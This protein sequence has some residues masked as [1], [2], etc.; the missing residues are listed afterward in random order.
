MSKDN[1]FKAKNKDLNFEKEKK[2]DTVLGR[3]N[4]DVEQK[5]NF[6]VSKKNRMYQSRQVDN[7]SDNATATDNSDLSNTP[8]NAVKDNTDFT[9]PEQTKTAESVKSTPKKQADKFRSDNSVENPIEIPKETAVHTSTTEFQADISVPVS[10]GERYNI[11]DAVSDNKQ[12][13]DVVNKNT[14]FKLGRQD[15]TAKGT[16]EQ[17]GIKPKNKNRLYQKEHGKSEKETVQNLSSEQSSEPATE[18]S[19]KSETTE[20]AESIDD[21]FQFNRTAKYERRAE[22]LYQKSEKAKKKAPHKTKI[23][24]RRVYDEK[25]QKAKNRLQFEDEPKPSADNRYTFVKNSATF[26]SN[27][28]L[29]KAHNKIREVENENTSVEAAHKTEEQTERLAA[30]SMRLQKNLR[31]RRKNAPLKKAERLRQKAENA[32]IKALYEKTLKEHPEL[33]KS[34]VKKFLQKQRIKKQYQKAKRAEQ[35]AKQA[36]KAA[37]NTRA[38]T[39]R[40]A[41]FVWRH[42]A[43]IGIILAIFLMFMWL[44]SV[45]SSCSIMGT[46]GANSLMVSSY[47]A[48]DEDIYAAEEYYAGLEQNLQSRINNIESEYSGYDEY[49]YN[50][51]G[52]GHNPYELISY[53]TAVYQD[54]KFNDIKS[55]L[56]TLFNT[57]YHLTITETSEQRTDEDGN[58]YTYKILNITLTNSG[59]TTTLNSEQQ[60][61]YN[62]Y[63][64]SKGNRDYLFA[65]DIYS[66]IT[67]SPYNDYEIPSAALSDAT[68]KKLI[69]EAEKYL[70]YPYVWG[71]SSPST[72][73]DCSGFVC[74]VF[75]NSGVYP[76][77]RTTAQGIF[78]QCTAVRPNEAK[79]GDIIF[80]TGTYNSGCPVSHVGIYVGN[81]MMIHCGNPIQYASVN[82]SYWSSHF[83][84]YGRLN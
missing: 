45:L 63:L 69:T 34:Q 55:G 62:I 81:G 49:N 50:V 7:V 64:A 80:F 14:D 73:F 5:D 16:Q 3:Q 27:K 31:A 60:E 6:S 72:S 35:T 78:N 40:I 42:K 9:V 25:K 4:R 70:G 26:A 20:N 58:T 32:E 11:Q 39:S 1:E 30:H 82:S 15:T 47:F 28:V 18:K 75:K 29:L 41:S 23:K 43:T 46:M 21:D 12:A 68:F 38:V 52:I 74:W 44:G 22:K 77:S 48:E 57:Q 53:L 59:F 84:A 76:L 61:L 83:Y 36:K 13:F 65:D 66:N 37:Q 33:K 24:R 54:F 71:G 8:E 2:V 51:V 10:K 67:Q 19:D 17:K 79:P 56:D